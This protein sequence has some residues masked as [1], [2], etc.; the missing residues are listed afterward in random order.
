MPLILNKT[1][2]PPNHNQEVKATVKHYETHRKTNTLQHAD[3]FDVHLYDVQANGCSY[4]PRVRTLTGPPRILRCSRGSHNGSNNVKY[5]S[6][7]KVT[8]QQTQNHTES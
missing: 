2:S 3:A 6:A 5:R 4:T 1:F 8:D 7:N